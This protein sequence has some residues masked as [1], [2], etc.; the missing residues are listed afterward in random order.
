[1]R[2]HDAGKGV[3][4]GQRNRRQTELGG[5]Q[6]LGLVEGRVE[7]LDAPGLKVPHIG[8]EPVSWAKDSEL[9]AGIAD[10]T[11]FYFVH[12]FVPQVADE[13]DALGWAEHGER[14]VCA[15]DRPP[16]YGVQFHPEKSSSAGLA[17]LANFLPG[18]TVSWTGSYLALLYGFLI[19]VALGGIVAGVW[20]VVHHIYLVFAVTRRYFAG[21][22]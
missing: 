11:P 12:S 6:G 9:T 17:L 1:M 8:W 22:L 10:G 16:I 3:A 19:G 7:G 14:F 20:N 2:A 4:V 15:I 13:A 18:Y 21:D 5:A